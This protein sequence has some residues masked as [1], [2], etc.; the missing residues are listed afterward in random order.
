MVNVSV[1]NQARKTN[2]MDNDRTRYTA[3]S[4]YDEPTGPIDV[5]TFAGMVGAPRW[6]VTR[7]AESGLLRSPSPTHRAS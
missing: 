4:P 1:Y 6:D 2:A 5:Q 3:P 7:P